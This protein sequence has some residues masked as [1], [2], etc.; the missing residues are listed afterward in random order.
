MYDYVDFAFPSTHYRKL[1]VHFSINDV[2]HAE[3]SVRSRMAGEMTAGWTALQALQACA[4]SDVSAREAASALLVAANAGGPYGP[5]VLKTIQAAGDA[6]WT[7]L[8]TEGG[9]P[10]WDMAQ[11]CVTV[12]LL[13]VV[14]CLLCGCDFGS[15][16]QHQHKH[17]ST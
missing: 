11:L 17:P 5:D 14:R 12:R 9:R 7:G 3:R 2:V 6:V 8:E 13:S 15:I 10:G 4:P 1:A 16:H